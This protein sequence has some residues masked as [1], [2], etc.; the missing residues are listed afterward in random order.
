MERDGVRI[1]WERYGDGERTVLLLPTWSVVHS[2][3][4][5]MQIPYLARH[6]RVVTFDGRGNGRS[7]RPAGAEANSTDEFAAD[8]LAV[9]DATGTERR[10][11]GGAVVRRA[12]GDDRRRQPSR[13]GGRDRLHRP[14]GPAGPR[15][16]RARRAR[17]TSRSTPT[18]GGRSTT[19]ST[20]TG[21]TATSSSSSS[22]NASTSRTRP[23]RSRTRSAGR[24]TRRPRRWRTRPAG[25]AFRATRT[26]PRCAGGSAARCSSSTA[27][28]TSSGRSG[29]ARRWPRRPAATFVTLEGA[30][31]IPN[32]RD[33]V[34]LNLLLRDFIGPPPPAR[35]WTR[36]QART[37]RALYISS[38]IGLGHARRDV[39]IA[40]ELRRLHPDLEIDWLAQHPVTE[41]LEAQ[42]RA[43]PPRQ[44]A[45]RRRVA[46][47]P[48]R[49]ARARAERVRGVPAD[50]RDPGRE[51]HGVPRPRHRRAVRPVDRRRGVGARLL[52]AREPRAEVGR[53]R[54]AERLRRLAADGRRRRARGAADPRLQR[55]DARADRA[56]P[57]RARPVAVRRRPRGRRARPLRKRSAEDPRLDRAA[58]QLHR[59]HHGI[60]SRHGRRSRRVAR[61]ARL[62][63]PRARVR[64]HRRRL[65]R[66]RAP[67]A[68]RDR[69]LPRGQ[70]A[71]PGAADD[72]RRRP[73]DRPRHPARARTDSR[74][75]DTSTTSTATWRRATWRSSRAG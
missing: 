50:G 11:P 45:A 39:A 9:M 46:A 53:L 41:V 13:A 31:H 35:R 33:P 62:R 56:L 12:V 42:R 4:W 63:R 54:M 40:S 38:P 18:R 60:R 66:R 20:G 6:F 57:A 23:S 17:S 43:D 64:R 69:E 58:L 28:P 2:R 44:R 73:A 27:T 61:R 75:A 55:R 1:F 74:S 21:T 67:A 34:K 10:D 37:R 7:D 47:H 32:A 72:R 5:K 15:P 8:A 30:G 14:R 16:P 36:G 22:P 71:R 59:L 29:R 3:F 70:A 24:S 52:P 48:I 49:G 68:A 25:S 65:G 19:A 26:S 51:L